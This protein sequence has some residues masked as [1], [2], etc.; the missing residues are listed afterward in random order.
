MTALAIT[1][2]VIALLLLPGWAAFEIARRLKG[3]VR[4]SGLI[5]L[6]VLP[7]TIYLWQYQQAVAHM[8]PPR[9]GLGF[10]DI[11]FKAAVGAWW[12]SVVIGLASGMVSVLQR[13]KSASTESYSS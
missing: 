11:L 4:W 5:A 13:S 3:L 7:V 1:G 8:P 10:I 9:D 12:L 6:L 2:L